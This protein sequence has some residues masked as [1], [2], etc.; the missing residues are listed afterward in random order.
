MGLTTLFM[1]I[2]IIHGRR[3]RQGTGF[4]TVLSC[5]ILHCPVQNIPR[6]LLPENHNTTFTIATKLWVDELIKTAFEAAIGLLPALPH[7]TTNLLIMLYFNTA[8]FVYRPPQWYYFFR[9]LASF[10]EYM[11]RPHTCAPKLQTRAYFNVTPAN[12]TLKHVTSTFQKWGFLLIQNSHIGINYSLM[13]KLI[14][15]S[16]N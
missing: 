3:T 10:P 15:I 14:H 5:T 1:T 6:I 7:D 4:H 13:R 2:L 12:S 8:A 9:S 11:S 16:A